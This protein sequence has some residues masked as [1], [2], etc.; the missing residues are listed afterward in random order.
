MSTLGLVIFDN[1]GVLVD[2]EQ[3]GNEVLS[4][5]L[6]R[7]GYPITFED[8]VR[9]FMGGT[10]ARTRALIEHDL[11]RA[12]TT[13]FEGLYRRELYQRFETELKAVPDA[14]RQVRALKEAGTEVCV[15]SSGSHDKIRR[16]LS[17][18]GLLE[19][20]DG[21]IFSA[22]DVAEGKPAPDLFE[23]VSA[24]LGVSPHQC[25]VLEDSPAGI[26]AA[27]AA[28]M[29]TIG[30]VGAHPG[31]GNGDAAELLEQAGAEV[32]ISHLGAVPAALQSLAGPA[33]RP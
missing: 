21:R 20:F 29:A 10:L 1:D 6:T 31:L 15:A 33:G 23:H 17:T 5:I 3:L 16:S 18:V 28:G 4:E 32:V 25:V 19:H 11:G 8:C 7:A 27:R 9:R 14:D 24:T 12:F 26:A 30:F 22:D 2:S 13:D